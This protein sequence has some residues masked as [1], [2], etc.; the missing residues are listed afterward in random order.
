MREKASTERAVLDALLDAALIGYVGL[1]DG[2][3]LPVV[4]PTAIARDADSLLLHGSTGAGWMRRL[5]VGAPCSVAVSSLDAL[6]VAR[7]A[8]ESSINY[9]SAVLFGSCTALAGAA[10]RRALDVFTEALLPGRTAEVRTP[11][12]VELAKTMVLSLPI[13]QWSLKV[14]DDFGEDGPDDVEGPAW[15]GIVPL[16]HSYGQP[17]PAPDLHAGIAVPDSV[18]RLLAPPADL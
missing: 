11:R 16:V 8:F 15:A 5:A 6:V 14:S 13:E 4:I 10:H 3:G 7:S 18:R 17:V 9:R 12:T 1:V 2:A